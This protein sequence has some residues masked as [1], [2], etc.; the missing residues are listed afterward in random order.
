MYAKS[1]CDQRDLTSP[2][3]LEMGMARRDN[4]FLSQ[5][6]VALH[7]DD[8]FP[9]KYEPAIIRAMELCAV[10]KQLRED[11]EMSIRVVRIGPG[12]PHTS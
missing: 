9:A 12:S 3:G 11:I 7:V 6:D 1:F 8:D 4:G 2:R 10:K 5:L